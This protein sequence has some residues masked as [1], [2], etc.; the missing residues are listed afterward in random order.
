VGFSVQPHFFSQASLA[1]LAGSAVAELG[2]QWVKNHVV[3]HMNS[4]ILILFA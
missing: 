2:S 3:P 4:N 1:F